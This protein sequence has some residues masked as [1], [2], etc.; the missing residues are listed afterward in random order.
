M[1]TAPPVWG[2]WS[3]EPVLPQPLAETVAAQLRAPQSHRAA[4]T[5]EVSIILHDPDRLHFG[6]LIH[7]YEVDGV[8]RACVVY[9]L[10][11]GAAAE[12]AGLKHLVPFLLHEVNG[13]EVRS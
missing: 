11:P 13:R 1:W 8:A 9:D 7:D 5:G 2:R 4:K 10:L 6:V 12:Q 3:I